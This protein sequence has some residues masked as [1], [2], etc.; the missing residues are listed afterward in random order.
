MT[1]CPGLYLSNLHP[2]LPALNRIGALERVFGDLSDLS[3]F[4]EG[5]FFRLMMKQYPHIGI[6]DGGLYYSLTSR[7]D[8]HRVPTGS[9]STA[10]T[11]HNFGYHSTRTAQFMPTSD[12]V[13]TRMTRELS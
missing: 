4:T 10:D 7:G 12:I 2:K 5:D 8:R 1:Y 3:A 11:L 13:V 9:Y 6:L